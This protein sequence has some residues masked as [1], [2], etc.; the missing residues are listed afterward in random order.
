M[1]GKKPYFFPMESLFLLEQHN[2]TGLPCSKIVKNI[3]ED[4]EDE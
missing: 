2:H 3:N 1:F 4:L